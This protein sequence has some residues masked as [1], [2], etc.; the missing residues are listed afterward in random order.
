MISDLFD[1]DALDEVLD[2]CERVS[3]H[4]GCVT[5]VDPDDDNSSGSPALAS[6]RRACTETTNRCDR[7]SIRMY[8]GVLAVRMS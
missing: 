7:V 5:L 3:V 6:N 4:R 1:L 2:T 8:P